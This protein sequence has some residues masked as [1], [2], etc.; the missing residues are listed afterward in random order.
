MNAQTDEYAYAPCK[1]MYFWVFI[2]QGPVRVKRL[3][4]IW[5]SAKAPHAVVILAGR[6]K[7]YLTSN[8]P[9]H[10]CVYVCT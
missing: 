10:T 4:L 7:W 5:L 2:C 3:C 8:K 6:Q 1:K 9:K